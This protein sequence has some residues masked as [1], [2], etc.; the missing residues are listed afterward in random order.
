MSRAR[1]IVS[2]LHRKYPDPRIALEYSNPLQLLIAVILSAQCTDARVNMVTPALFEKYTNARTLAEAEQDEIEEAIRTTGFYRSKAKN[3]IA[4]CKALVENHN[5]RV[6]STMEE[7]TALPGVGRK[8]ANC[9]LSS[10]FGVASGV[11]VDT[12]VIRLATRLGLTTNS[13][14]EKI[15]ADLCELLPRDEWIHFGNA[16]IHHGRKI[17]DARRPLCAECVLNR[18]C[19]SAN[20]R[21]R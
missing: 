2:L 6:P 7:L 12:H 8:T 9:V 15:E 10:A 18:L 4:C 17:C 11:V 1:R 3:I 13:Q 14:P 21:T 19:P 5:G 16:L 20:N